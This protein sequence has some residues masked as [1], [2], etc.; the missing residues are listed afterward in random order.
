[1]LFSLFF[2]FG[3]AAQAAEPVVVMLNMNYSSQELAA[4]E[5]LAKSRGQRVEMVP[6]KDMIPQVEDLFAARFALEKKIKEL[7]PN[8]K[9]GQISGM[10]ADYMRRGLASDRDTDLNNALGADVEALHQKALAV[11]AREEKL[12]PVEDQ[13]RKKVA[14]L[15]SQG[16]TIDTLLV[17]SHSDGS[18][19]SG[20]TS[21][22]LSSSS[23]ARLA[24][25][26]S[27]LFRDPRH[28][29]LM[30]CYN[31][32]ET[33][34]FRWRN[35]LFPS[36]SLIG[37]YGVR[38]PSRYRAISHQYIT[39]VLGTADALDRKMVEE[40]SLLPPSYVNEV[41]KKLKSVTGAES[42]VI[43]YCS[44]IV[45][46][47]PGARSLSCED[48]WNA[49]RGNSQNFQATFLDL[50]NPQQDPPEPSEGETGELRIFYN[51]VQEIC[52]AYKAPQIPRSEME[53]AEK[54]R[55]SIRESLIRLIHWWEVQKN[56][57]TYYGKELS[58]LS[59]SLRASGIRSRLP[60][61]DGNSGR[62]EFIKAYNRI[63][64]E[65]RM[66]KESLNSQRYGQMDYAERARIESEYANL[67]ATEDKF[68]VLYPLFTLEGE[69]TVGDKLSSGAES[70]LQK[71]GIPFNWINPGA[72]VAP[73]QK[74]SR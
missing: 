59:R 67:Q 37:G 71:G 1:M 65:I 39:E 31:M 5:K 24:K 22:R 48:Q 9:K 35:N 28:V 21:L 64:N 26:S 57:S 23:I 74:G 13:L 30:G 17:S 73:R 61:L 49:F 29:L 20:E 27:K 69:D 33:N 45:E 40:R 14:Q 58:D 46:G 8:F 25:D 55:V 51:E 70:T 66:R 62:V 52:P 60:D 38:A 47:R 11:N 16:A 72:V 54:Y 50:S 2:F 43:D 3:I 32:T 53:R 18:N 56:F 42:A 41:F 36:A 19:L 4:L 10:L 44:A 6:P 63:E 34:H 15:A 68:G 7:R 12:G